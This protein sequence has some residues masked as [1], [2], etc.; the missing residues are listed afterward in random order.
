VMLNSH[1]AGWRAAALAIALAAPFAM[2]GIGRTPFDDPGEG[3]HAQIARELIL[4]GDP[5]AL[6]LNGVRYVDKP[7]LLY[8]LMALS[9]AIGGQTEAS[10]RIVPALAALAAVGATTWLGA[11]L[12]GTA[13]G[14]LAGAALLT[15]L[16]FFAYSHY[17]PPETLFVAALALGFALALVG[18]AEDRRGLAA[19]G[20]PGLPRTR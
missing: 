6:T 20:V 19:F 13:A 12:L 16:G 18:L 14:A 7:P 15:S 2:V 9:F 5:V 10:A 11:Y 1:R 4:S 3:M 17:V 8:A